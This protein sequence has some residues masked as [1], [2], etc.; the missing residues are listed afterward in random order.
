MTWWGQRSPLLQHK[1]DAYPTG[2]HTSV[3][4]L[5]SAATKYFGPCESLSGMLHLLVD[6]SVCSLQKGHIQ[7]QG[8]HGA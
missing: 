8:V 5:I 6:S 2:Q 3:G 7:K 1:N 4:F